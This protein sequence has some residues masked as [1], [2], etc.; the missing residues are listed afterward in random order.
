MLPII[1]EL[2]NALVNI[3]QRFMLAVLFH[4]RHDRGLPPF[5][6]FFQRGDI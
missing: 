4:A 5:G 2:F 1:L 3:R 6:Q